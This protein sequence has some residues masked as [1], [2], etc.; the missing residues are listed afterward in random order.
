[1]VN[2]VLYVNGDGVQKQHT[3]YKTLESPVEEQVQALRCSQTNQV[4]GD[5][6]QKQHALQ[7]T[8]TLKS[9]VGEHVQALRCSQANQ[10]NAGGGVQTQHALQND[11]HNT[12]VTCR[13]ACLYTQMQSEKLS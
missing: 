3:R 1:M 7:N 6:V 8:E 4:N 12:G 11:T 10:I 5:G 13:R 9:S 2:L